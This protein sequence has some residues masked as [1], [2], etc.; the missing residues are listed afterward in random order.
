MD[1]R[2]SV[3][4]SFEYTVNAVAASKV[5]AD[6]AKSQFLFAVQDIAFHID[7]RLLP[8]VWCHHSNLWSYSKPRTDL[9]CLWFHSTTPLPYL[10]T[11]TNISH[12]NINISITTTILLR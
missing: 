12:K 2:G 6:T 1:T 10:A 4:S 11:H 9:C 5:F 8:M 7:T 3:C